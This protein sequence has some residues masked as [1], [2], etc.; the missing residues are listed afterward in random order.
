MS[1]HRSDKDYIHFILIFR[2]KQVLKF[3]ICSMADSRLE[4]NSYKIH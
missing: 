4:Y 3:N 2:E 1:T